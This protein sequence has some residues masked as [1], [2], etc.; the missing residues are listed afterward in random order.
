MVA[1]G[2]TL[3]SETFLPF[4]GEPSKGYPSFRGLSQGAI[5]LSESQSFWIPN[6]FTP[7]PKFLF[8]LFLSI[9]NESSKDISGW[10]QD[11]HCNPRQF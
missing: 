10:I 8:C 2:L 1:R 11:R 3:C 9:L 6:Y 7:F 5:A 4:Q